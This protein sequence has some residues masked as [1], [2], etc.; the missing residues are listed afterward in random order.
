MSGGAGGGGSQ[1]FKGRHL[2]KMMFESRSEPW[3]DCHEKF[4]VEHSRQR[5]EQGQRPLGRKKLGMF[6]E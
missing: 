6:T 1:G 2:E 4:Q 5:K 3:E